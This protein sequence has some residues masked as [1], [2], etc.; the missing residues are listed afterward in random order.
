MA[1]FTKILLISFRG[2]PVFRITSYNVCYTKLLRTAEGVSE[3]ASVGGF[4]KEYQIDLNPEALKA[5]RVTVMDVMA[6]VSKSNLDIGAETIELNKVEYLIRGLG[7]VKNLN[8]IEVTVVAVRNNVPVRIQDI[9]K[10]S[11]GRN[12][13]V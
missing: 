4:V 12:N 9:A 1:T 5:F 2:I 11:Y 10:V 6:A 13:F 8:D 7:Y 3:V